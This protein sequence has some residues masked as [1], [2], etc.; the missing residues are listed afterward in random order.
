[1]PRHLPKRNERTRPHRNV[2]TNVLSSFVCSSPNVE[3]TQMPTTGEWVNARCY[4]CT[5]EYQKNEPLLCVTT[6]VDLKMIL[7]GEESRRKKE[8][9]LLRKIVYL[10]LQL[11]EGRGV[12]FQNCTWVRTVALCYPVIIISSLLTIK[13]NHHCERYCLK[14]RFLSY[15]T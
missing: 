5:E 14:G 9:V 13:S 7:L 11:N 6:W 15:Q 4:S 1:M 3:T 12:Q 2:H 10:M 8:F